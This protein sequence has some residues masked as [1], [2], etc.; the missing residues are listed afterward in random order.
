M[1]CLKK[2]YVFIYYVS[3]FE[4]KFCTSLQ[5]FF[6]LQQLGHNPSP[7][8]NKCANWY[9]GPCHGNDE[10][11]EGYY[12]DPLRISP[13]SDK[14]KLHKDIFGYAEKLKKISLL[15][16]R[17][18]FILTRASNETLISLTE[19]KKNE[20]FYYPENSLTY[21]NLLDEVSLCRKHQVYAR[22]TLATIMFF[23]TIS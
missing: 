5:H 10:Y 20:K 14:R 12:N 21:S 1:L 17:G 8:S 11:H 22:L 7:G 23:S 4:S 2:L 18:C 16:Q 3:G 13:L 19:K 6:I 15:L 9:F